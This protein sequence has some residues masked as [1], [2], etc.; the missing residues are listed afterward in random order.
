MAIHPF[1]AWMLG[2]EARSLLTRLTRVKPFAL[3][4]PM[5]P[6][7][8]LQPG[9]QSAIER[10][11]A[12][13]RRQ[14]RGQVMQFLR[15]LRSP[16][17]QFADEAE[18]QRRF[19]FLRLRFNAMLTHVD[20]FS[21]VITQRSECENGVW[22]AGLDVVCAETLRLPG[23]YYQAPPVVCY[24]DRGPG[25]AIRRAGT[26]LPGGGQNPV[27]IVRIP[28]ERMVGAGIASSLVHEIGHQA[29]ALLDL[30]QSLRP[31]IQAMQ[32]RHGGAPEQDPWHWWET[33]ISEIVADFWAVSRVG[34]ASTM[35]LIAVLSLPRLFVLRLSGNDPHPVPWLRVM[36]SCAI[37]DALY[38]HP[39]WRRLSRLWDSYYPLQGL[40]PQR[41]RLYRDLQRSIPAFVRLLLAHRPA[42]LHGHSLPELCQIEQ[43]QPAQL[44]RL[45]AAWRAAPHEMYQA[46]P[47]L[48][49]A[50]FGQ[51]RV[52]GSLTPEAESD[53]LG[54][55]L[56]HWALQN[57]L[58]TSSSCAISLGRSAAQVTGMDSP[59]Q[60]DVWRRRTQPMP[61]ARFRTRRHLMHGAP[62]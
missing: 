42:S 17:A 14:L 18:G 57:S 21:E 33:W 47:S 27:A 19:T 49:F 6:A 40:A 41:L 3:L 54:K 1:A 46:P 32:G 35:G 13:C 38:P 11:V 37:G 34:V 10:H 58:N 23:D 52:D 8:A 60:A 22:L 28:R 20:L 2:Q 26:R 59:P 36:L 12:L 31:E 15:W 16:Q 53:V 55:L 50:V 5:V 56:T 45:F 25:A 51:A 48:V 29:A 43:R 61:Q 24:L 39:Q 44:A 4:Q 9:A 7:A 30:A 62:R